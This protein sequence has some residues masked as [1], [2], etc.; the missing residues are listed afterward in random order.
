MNRTFRAMLVSEPTPGQFHRQITVR[1]LDDL[2]AGEVLVR[3]RYSSLNYKDALSA[4]GNRG[5]TRRYPH[6]PGIDAAG[7]VAESRAPQFKPG[8]A[9]M[10]SCY[11]LGMNT[12]GGFGQYI[13][14]PA[15]WVMPLPDGLTARESMI[16]GTAGFTA[17]QC[18]ERLLRHPV[19]P[20]DGKILVTGATGG[21]GSMAVALLAGQGFHVAAVTGKPEQEAFLRGLG[22]REIVPR[23]NAIDQSARMLLKEKWAG[24]VDTVGGP[25][26][27]TAVKS[28][29]YGGAATCCGNAASPDLSLNVY[30]FILRGVS[31]I[32]IDSAECPM[33]SRLPLWQRL[34]S[35]WRLPNLEAMAT[36]ISL[37][38]LDQY[39][40]SILQ[41]K[42][43]GRLILNLDT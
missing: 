23:Q 21:V 17:A 39:I 20:E 5:V 6:T 37:M 8:E 25:I 1:E 9:V 22:A 18:M 13:R 43:R 28:T 31:L 27:A 4:T 36:E 42:V 29:R 33:D 10:V 2:P 38:E 12:P 41:G 35:D 34:A 19:R 24:V 14:V 26:L 32:G 16:Y 30:P 7:E 40:D 11:D 3:V 15:A